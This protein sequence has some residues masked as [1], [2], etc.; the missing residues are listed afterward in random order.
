MMVRESELARA[1][2]DYTRR[3]SRGQKVW[4]WKSFHPQKNSSGGRYRHGLGHTNFAWYRPLRLCLMMLGL[5]FGE[6]MKVKCHDRII[7]KDIYSKP[8]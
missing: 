3:Y 5:Y 7:Y 2:G 1:L 4:T 6:T 8:T